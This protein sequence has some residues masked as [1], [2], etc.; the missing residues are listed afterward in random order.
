MLKMK[1]HWVFLE[2]NM[3]SLEEIRLK[4]PQYS[5]RSD[6]EL[7]DA[8]HAKYYSHIPKE[9]FYEKI[10]FNPT[11][12]QEPFMEKPGL[13]GIAS[14]LMDKGL[15]TAMGIPEAIMGAPKEAYG[16]LKQ[17]INDPKRAA[18]NVGAGFGEL[19]H[20]ILSAPGNV[21]DYLEKKKLISSD[22]PSFRIPESI[23]PKEYDYPS[24]LGRQGHESG[25]TLLTGL[26]GSIASLPLSNALFKAVESI[27]LTKTIAARPLVK[28]ENMVKESGIKS[29][30]ISKDIFKDASNYLPKNIST[31]N[32][33][34]EA[35]K[36][37]Y[38]KLF[39]LQSDLGKAGRELRKSA[40]GAERLHG[41]E[42]EKLR[43]NLLNE[44]KENLSK[45]GLDDA[46]KML[47]KGQNKYRQHHKI[48]KYVYKPL[49]KAGIPVGIMSLLGWGYNNLNKKSRD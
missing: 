28:A 30:P 12:K 20:G 4:Y 32:L 41:I 42:A 13:S 37:D 40:S 17:I 29:L 16:A 1:I 15:T 23:L 33:I 9:Q 10:N 35:S 48:D 3:A 2:N 31:Q 14:D 5:N 46:A 6:E 45:S 7:A 8:L 43:R 38:S 21:R 36:G 19:G 39:T 26:P 27:P 11:P 18:Q 22:T 49:Q 24:A 44:I 47:T 25:D 34:K